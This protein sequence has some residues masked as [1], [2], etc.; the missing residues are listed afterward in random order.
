MSQL[1]EVLGKLD[2][3][4]SITGGYAARCP[5]PSHGKGRGDKR[6]SLSVSE[7]EDK[8]LLFCH[9]G[10]SFTD[11]IK[12]LGLENTPP[13]ESRIVAEYD[14]RDENGQ[15]SFQVVRFEPK[16]FRQRRW[17]G[18]W[19]WDRRGTQPV[20]FNLQQILRNEGKWI[21]FVEGEK[22]VITLAHHDIVGTCIAG[23]A[24]GK[25]ND[26]YTKS[27]TGRRVAIIPDNDLPGLKFADMVAASLYGWAESIKIVNI[28]GD[29]TDWF[30]AGGDRDKL[31]TILS[32]SPEYKPPAE[33]T[34]AE[35]D[36]LRDTVRQL[37]KRRP[38]RDGV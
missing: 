16:G 9:A 15:L 26:A 8:L 29:A 36:A 33:V 32:N 17:D 34:R 18:G 35:F 14:Y 12:E 2:G 31:A 5:V 20:L 38:R 30:N 24:S 10:C 11:V 4:K 3:V 6:T 22:D 7:S 13:E 25:W 37:Y 28:A 21:F 23:G 19:V 1:Q 27:L